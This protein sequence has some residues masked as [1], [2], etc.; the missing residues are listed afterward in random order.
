MVTFEASCLQ[1]Q[2][3]FCRKKFCFW[4]NLKSKQNEYFELLLF[5]FIVSLISVKIAM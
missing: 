1:I 3:S 4:L 5:V 2:T